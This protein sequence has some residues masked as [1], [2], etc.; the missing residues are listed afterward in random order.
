M[1]IIDDIIRQFDLLYKKD[2]LIFAIIGFILVGLY[3][4]YTLF[5]R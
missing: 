2:V 1:Q 4:L 3:L 5:F